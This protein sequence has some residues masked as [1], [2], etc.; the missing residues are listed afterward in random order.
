MNRDFMTPWEQSGNLRQLD[1]PSLQ[2]Q[3]Q[4]K[5]LAS[6]EGDALRVDADTA[7]MA[8]PK[9]FLAIFSAVISGR[10]RARAACQSFSARADSERNAKQIE[11]NF[12]A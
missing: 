10:S 2:E 11:L 9:T 1:M 3:S 7:S 5:C 8:Y 6:S 4:G 12:H